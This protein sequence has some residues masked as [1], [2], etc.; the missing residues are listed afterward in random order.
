[1][2]NYILNIILIQYFKISYKKI[3]SKD[4]NNI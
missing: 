3:I 2:I 4:K 1:M